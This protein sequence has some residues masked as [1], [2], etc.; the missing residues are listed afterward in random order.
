MT[1]VWNL[2]VIYQG[3]EDPA[4]E[5]D[6]KAFEEVVASTAEMIEKAKALELN[7][8][9]ISNNVKIFFI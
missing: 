7:T 3:L 5:A 1:T 4:Y 8:K 6:V 2:D 9:N